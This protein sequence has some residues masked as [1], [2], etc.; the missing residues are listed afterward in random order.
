MVTG[1]GGNPPPKMPSHLYTMLGVS[2]TPAFVDC[3]KWAAW[4]AELLPRHMGVGGEGE[5]PAEP[6]KDAVSSGFYTQSW[7]VSQEFSLN[8]CETNFSFPLWT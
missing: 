3:L 7:V 2:C 8:S 5:V 1:D 6:S 4:E